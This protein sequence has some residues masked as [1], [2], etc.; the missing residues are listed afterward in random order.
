MHSEHGYS[1]KEPTCVLFLKTIWPHSNYSRQWRAAL[2]LE[3]LNAGGSDPRSAWMKS[4]SS[5]VA[6]TSEL[7]QCGW[8]SFLL[9][10]SIS[11]FFFFF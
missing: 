3:I 9:N 5:Y 11:P 6:V 10:Q 1:H 8:V 7:S 4:T 2:A